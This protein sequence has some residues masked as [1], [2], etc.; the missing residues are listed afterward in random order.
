MQLFRPSVFEKEVRVSQEVSKGFTVRA[1]VV[2]VV[3]CF[4]ISVFSPYGILMIKGSQ[5]A[6]NFSTT[7]AMVMLLI[8]VLIV[9]TILRTIGR[10]LGFSRE[11]LVVIYVMMIIGCAIPTQGLTTNLLPIM[12]GAFY[13]ATPENDW[14]HLVQPYI[15]RW[16]VPQHPEVVVKYFYEGLSEGEVIPWMAWIKP[17][18]MWLP[19]LLA[20]WL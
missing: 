15:P 8:L 17:L 11:E 7:G 1:F 14:V 9:N 12:S 10:R 2:G 3:G 18:L 19:L 20:F 13:Y 6:E 4:L 5:M 16:I